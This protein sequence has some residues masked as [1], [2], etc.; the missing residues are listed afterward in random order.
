[1]TGENTQ[2]RSA[3]LNHTAKNR[4]LLLPISFMKKSQQAENI[5]ALCYIVSIIGLLT[6]SPFNFQAFFPSESWVTR[7]S[8]EDVS[9][10]IL[11]FLPFGILLR[12]ALRKPHWVALLWGL[13][14]SL[15]VE[16]TQLFIILRTSNFI[17][18][19]SNSTGALLGSVLYSRLYSRYLPL[20]DAHGQSANFA[21]ALMLAPLC[22]LNA[23]RS[24]TDPAAAWL[25][26][27]N[28]IAGIILLQSSLFASKK[29]KYKLAAVWAAIALIPLLN[30]SPKI[31]PAIFIAMPVVVYLSANIPTIIRARRYAFGLTA[32]GA[33][34]VSWRLVVGQ[35]LLGG[36][37]LASDELIVRVAELVLSVVATVAIE[38]LNNPSKR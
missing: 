1:M 17:D 29:L 30:T 9:R 31:A 3:L 4:L 12:H 38:I 23:F 7:A 13:L 19:A 28:A 18:L 25:S 16:C 11:L 36:S 24:I 14:L 32:M 8:V 6:L 10:N 26:G 35:R 15:S 33:V 34:I 2:D 21:I 27:I 37:N 20:V 22:W 5:L